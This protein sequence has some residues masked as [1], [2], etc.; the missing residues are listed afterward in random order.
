[1]TISPIEHDFPTEVWFRNPDAYVRELVEVGVGMVAWD[2]GYLVKKRIDPC[3][4]AQLFM[5]QIPWRSLAIGPQGTAEY[6]PGDEY[7][8]PSAV[9]PTFCYGDDPDKLESMAEFPAG[10]DEDLCSDTSLAL[11]ERPRLGQEHRIVI[12]DVPDMRQAGGRAFL[13]MLTE[14]QQ[15]YPDCII[16]LHGLYGYRL[17]FGQPLRSVDYEARTT[18]QKGK[19]VTPAGR[20]MQFERLAAHAHWA[21]MLGMRPGELAIPR[22]RCIYNIRSVLWAGINFRKDIKYRA[23]GKGTRVDDGL[24]EAVLAIEA[25]KEEMSPEELDMAEKVLGQLRE[26]A[27]LAGGTDTTTPTI[28][29]APVTISPNSY[30]TRKGLTKSGLKPQE[31]D[32]FHCDTCSLADHCKFQRE[33]AVC[34]VPSSETSQLAKLFGSRSSDKIID[35]LGKLLEIQSERVETGRDEEEQFGELNPE[36]S[37]MLNSL[38]SNGVK[39]AKLIDPTLNGGPKVN[40]NVGVGHGGQA[41]VMAGSPNQLMGAIIREIE[42]KGVPREQITPEM[43]QGVLEGMSGSASPTPAIEGHVI[44]REDR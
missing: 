5:G 30:R 2:R 15:E 19:V 33:G 7:G 27:G 38:F 31:G 28:G 23:Y 4:H 16:H 14:I 32:Y 1:M 6:R 41:A 42:S 20:E 35:G 12:S 3:M 37:K 18:A 13:R 40:V 22:N 9:Y 36:V 26:N 43:I 10:E 44:S 8:N 34:S 29:Y 24:T 17:M 25:R 21:T 11:D 39:L